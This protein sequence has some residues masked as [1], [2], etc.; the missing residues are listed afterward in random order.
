M[1][2]LPYRPKGRDSRAEV[3]RQMALD[4]EMWLGCFED[5]ILVGIVVGTYESR[6]GWINRL[7]VLPEHRGR[8]FGKALVLE[9]ERRLRA[10]GLA[11]FAALIEDGHDASLRLFKEAGYEEYEGIRYL[12]KRDYPEV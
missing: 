10:K 4:P 2:G 6:K 12:R 1:A 9:M 5:G 3:E 11:I 8:G 7:A